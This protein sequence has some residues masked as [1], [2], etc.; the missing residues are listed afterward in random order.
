MTQSNVIPIKFNPIFLLTNYCNSFCPHCHMSAGPHQAKDF[1]DIKDVLFYLDQFDKQPNFLKSIGFNGGEIMTAYKHHSPHYIPTLIQECVNRNYRIDLRTNAL[2][3][4]D[5]TINSIIWESLDNIDFSKYKSKL[6]FSMSIDKF[7]NNETA[8]QRLMAR[9]CN[10]DWGKHC[11]LTAYLIP[12]SNVG[13]ARDMLSRVY[14]LLSGKIVGQ[15]IQQYSPIK[16]ADLNPRYACGIYLNGIKF[17]VEIHS[18]GQWGRAREF[19][20]GQAWDTNG[21]IASQFNILHD[22][23]RISLDTNSCIKSQPESINIIFSS[24]GMADFI[25]PIHKITTGVPFHKNNGCKPLSQLYPEMV[26]HIQTR[27]NAVQ[28]QHPTITPEAV[29]LP[30]IMQK[31]QNTK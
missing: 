12:D 26:S 20:I 17:M 14:G 23:Q 11:E 2:W 10:S 3:T 25:V 8:N 19:G 28:K 29:K 9:V 22:H 21:A 7:H 13:D 18:V 6:S 24:D 27:F 4:E 1:I 16:Q 31:L 15:N 30:L 5:N